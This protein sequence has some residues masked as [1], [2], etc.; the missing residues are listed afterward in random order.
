LF[1]NIEPG[2]YRIAFQSHNFAEK[3]VNMEV[4]SEQ[5]IVTLETIYLRRKNLKGTIHGIITDESGLPV[6]KA[7]VVLLNSNNIPIQFTHT[8][9]D[10]VYLFYRLEPGTYSVIAK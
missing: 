7:L 3:I 9:E 2:F 1:D 8:N 5:P 4:G 10:G 6:D